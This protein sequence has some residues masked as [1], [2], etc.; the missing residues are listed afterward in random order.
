MARAPSTETRQ[1]LDSYSTPRHMESASTGST[2]THRNSIGSTGKQARPR[3]P[4]SRL[5]SLTA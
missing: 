4:H 2:G 5:D 1:E 3:Q